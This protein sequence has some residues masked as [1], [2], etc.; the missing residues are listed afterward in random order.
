MKTTWHEGF[1]TNWVCCQFAYLPSS[2]LQWLLQS[3]S[4][5][6]SAVRPSFSSMT[7]RA[8]QEEFVNKMYSKAW[9]L[10]Q[11]KDFLAPTLCHPEDAST[12]V[13]SLPVLL[14]FRETISSQKYFKVL[15]SCSRP[16]RM[17]ELENINEMEL[18]FSTHL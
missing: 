3:L 13:S 11:T 16:E 15:S 17:N 8:G 7:R 6:S 18:D 4:C 14:F 9:A 2:Q 12:W 5:P 10:L 1:R